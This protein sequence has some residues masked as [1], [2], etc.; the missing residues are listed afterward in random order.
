MVQWLRLCAS[1]AKGM[2]SIP[3]QGTKIP[4]AAQCG[5]ENILKK[6]KERSISWFSNRNGDVEGSVVTGQVRA[7]GLW[8]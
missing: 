7:A 1:N 8:L 6:K 2:G 5:Q 4:H 3:V